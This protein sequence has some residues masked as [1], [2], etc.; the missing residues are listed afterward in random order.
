M[1][2]KIK[3]NEGNIEFPVYT[4]T[5][6]ETMKNVFGTDPILNESQSN[7]AIIVDEHDDLQIDILKLLDGTYGFWYGFK[8]DFNEYDA[9][10]SDTLNDLPELV[11]I[12]YSSRKT[13]PDAGNSL[14]PISSGN[15]Q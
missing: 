14:K 9:Y 5:E 13:I 2:E 10:E 12:A 1:L 8:D 4:E 15:A 3:M 6:I 11:K 7:I